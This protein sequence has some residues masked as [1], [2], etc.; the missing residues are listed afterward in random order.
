MNKVY[1]NIKGPEAKNLEYAKKNVQKVYALERL[2]SLR[3]KN[4][5]ERTWAYL[6]IHYV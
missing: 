3:W 2:R 5:F 1:E 6:L 4:F